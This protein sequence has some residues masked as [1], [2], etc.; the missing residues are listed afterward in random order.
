M[1]AVPRFISWIILAAA[2]AGC[3]SKATKARERYE[4]L[5]EQHASYADVCS[6]GREMVR[7]YSE[8]GDKQRYGEADGVVET[9]CLTGDLNGSEQPYGEPKIEADNMDAIVSDN[10]SGSGG[11]RQ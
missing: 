11:A 10:A 4:F 8:A 5:K 1:R 2:L 7:A 6:A 3:S 9:D